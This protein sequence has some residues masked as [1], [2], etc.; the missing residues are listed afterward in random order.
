MERAGR[1]RKQ[2]VAW[3]ACLGISRCEYLV[4]HSQKMY[5]DIDYYHFIDGNTKA[6]RLRFLTS[7]IT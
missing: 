7:L 2:T 4:E 6:E 3:I 5:V 1:K